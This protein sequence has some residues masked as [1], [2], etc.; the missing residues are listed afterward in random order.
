MKRTKKNNKHKT[1]VFRYQLIAIYKKEQCFAIA[2]YVD[3][4]R[5]QRNIF[6]KLLDLWIKRRSPDQPMGN[7]NY[8]IV[9][10][11]GSW[12]IWNIKYYLL[13]A[14]FQA[15]AIKCNTNY[16]WIKKYLSLHCSDIVV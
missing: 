2:L 4:F 16:F 7:L 9:V 10:W 14:M 6:W 15:V 3:R 11:V 1:E 13:C 12:F 5:D 8:H